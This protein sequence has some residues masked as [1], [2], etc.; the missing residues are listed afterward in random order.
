MRVFWKGGEHH[1]IEE[2]EMKGKEPKDSEIQI[3][4]WKDCT[5]REL[6]GLIQQVVPIANRRDAKLSFM[7]IYHDNYRG[8]PRVS[9]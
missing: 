9:D 8:R 3:Y 7:A 5:L 6:T 2:F 1:R 4:T